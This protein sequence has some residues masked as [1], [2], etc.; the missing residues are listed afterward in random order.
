MQMNQSR[1][2]FI[3]PAHNEAGAV[4]LVIKEIKTRFP[5][6]QVVVC[7]N[8]STDGTAAEATLA[9]AKVL[10]ESRRGKGMAVRRLMRDIDA[11]VYVMIDGDNTY[12]MSYIG[13]AIQLFVRDSFD[14]MTGNRFDQPSSS[15]M[16][17]GHGVANAL[18]TLSLKKVCGIHTNDL[19]SGLRIMSRRFV[20]SFPMI[21]GNFEV[22]TEISV[23]AAKMQ[24]PSMDFP[25][26]V[27]SRKG[28][29]SKLNSFEDGLKI[30]LF[31]FRLLHR[32]YPL[33]LYSALSILMAFCSSVALVSVAIDFMATGLV[34]RIPTFFAAV[35]GLVITLVFL[36]AGLILKEIVNLK[37]EARYLAYLALS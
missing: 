22:E 30:L 26:R 34:A 6:A 25:T 29:V 18:F 32:E 3:V 36:V 15:S 13:E 11:D 28:T 1:V 23:Y 4:G 37:Y 8:A 35:S 21:S 2:S 31:V 20:K 5:S 17:K 19:F 24:V 14:L 10:Y 7:D 27:E 16:R 33:R 9:G 12:D